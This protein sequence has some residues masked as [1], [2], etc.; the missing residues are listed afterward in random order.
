MDPYPPLAGEPTEIC[1]ELRNLS[2]VTRT[3]GA[4]FFTAAFGIGLPWQ[5]L[6]A[7]MAEIPPHGR[8][9]ICLA[10]V[11]PVP[12]QFCVQVILNDASQVYA[13]QVSQRNLDVQEVLLPGKPTETIFLVGNPTGVETTLLLEVKRYLPGWILTVDPP[14]LLDMKPDEVRPV[15]LVVTPPPG[16]MPEDGAVVADIEAYYLSPI[17]ERVLVGGFRKI[18]R[19][20]VP[21]H[22]PHEPPYAESEIMIEPY[23]PRAG[24]PAVIC[25]EI[26]NPTPY[27]QTVQVEFGVANFG[28]GLRFMPIDQQTVV[29]PPMSRTRVCTRW[30]P[31]IGGHF[32]AQVI[33]RQPGYR[34]V[35]SQRNM[36]VA[37]FLVPGMPDHFS[38]PVGNPFPNRS[39]TV[40]LGM[41]E[42]L[43]G[44]SAELSSYVIPD[45]PPHAFKV[46][47]LTV[48]P[49]QDLSRI[50]DGQPVIDIEGYFDGYLLGGFRKLFRPPISIH[51][52]ADPPYAEREITIQPYPPRAGEPTEICVELRNPTAY[53]QTVWVEFAWA[54][55]GIGLPFHAFHGQSVTLPPYSLVKKCTKWVPPFAGRFCVQVTVRDPKSRLP[56]LRS[57][58]NLDVGEVF[59][60]GEWTAPL[61]FP[62]GN[63]FTV[64]TDIRLTPFVHRDGWLARLEPPSLPAM[65]PGETRPVTLTVY[66]PGGPLPEDETPVVDV[67]AHALGRLIGGF[68][69][70]YRPPVPIHL[71]KDPIYAESEISITPYP[72]RE[73][74]PTEICVDVRN[75]TDEPQTFTVTLAVANFGI[76]LPF[77][78]IARPIVLTLPPHSIRRACV[79]WV[80]P[81]GG[82]FCARVTL[83]MAGHRPVWSQRNLD[84]SEVLRPGEPSQLA[85]P[86]G[87]PTERTITITLG[88]VPYLENWQYAL[89]QDVLPSMEP[90]EIRKV[91]LTVTPPAAGSHA[92]RWIAR[93]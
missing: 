69:K 9:R 58:R 33:I 71:P 89:S 59:R 75:P 8:T 37:E 41:V 93:R 27:T 19:P 40:T 90:G 65:A 1:V 61:V 18:F 16:D 2:D 17:Q 10:W 81:F 63:P 28:I 5:P 47:T 66:V 85:F 67:E 77:H 39:I 70:V 87:N 53:S 44:W 57:Q 76:G 73:R 78:D 12:G 49:D 25:T 88:M 11:P 54:N 72:P 74:Q 20:P 35:F 48:T 92:G 30:V 91:I 51:R 4:E 42:H 55:F 21:I 60:P 23:P 80:P 79:T 13:P 64:T 29:L 50:E 84:V 43:A 82:Q 31:S 34:D 38:F 68:R 26:R 15:T 6:G 32:C 45:I 86:V 52:P 22:R 3:V 24:E 14:E 46:V 62:V 7:R 36:D 56:D 83:E